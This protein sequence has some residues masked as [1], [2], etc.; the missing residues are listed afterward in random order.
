MARDSSVRDSGIAFV[1][2]VP[3]TD[4]ARVEALFYFNPRQGGRL[5]QIRRT[6]EETGSPFIEERDQRIWI[7]V[8]GGTT[9]CLFACLP[10]DR[11]VGVALY[12]RPT[13]DLI[14][15]L[16]LA[17]ESAPGGRRRDEGRVAGA[18]VDK[19]RS[20]AGRIN[21]VRRVQLP[22]RPDCFL[23]VLMSR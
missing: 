13:N 6:V 17:V 15:I 10:S 16:H 3:A 23:R 4:R 1:G 11:P 5:S 2:S 19:I 7:G 12:C 22:Y 8:P 20:I 18:M 21:G 9:Q 14:R